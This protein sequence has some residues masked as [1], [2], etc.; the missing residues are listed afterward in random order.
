[1]DQIL[2]LPGRTARELDTLLGIIQSYPSVRSIILFGSTARGMRNEDSDID[3]LVLV[4][5]RGTH[6]PIDS[7][8]IWRDSFGKITFPLD[9]I[10][11]TMKDFEERKSFPTLERKIAREGKVLYAD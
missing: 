1:M 4:D 3:L 2:D 6:E 10:V 7:A 9:V 11:E 8:R 5:D